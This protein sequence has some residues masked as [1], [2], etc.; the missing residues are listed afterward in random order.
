MKYLPVSIAA[1][2]VLILGCGGTAKY[3]APS[4]APPPGE[5]YGEK[6]SAALD[7]TTGVPTSWTGRAGS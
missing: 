5:A 2:A 6:R 7:A 3:A 1:L 4:Y